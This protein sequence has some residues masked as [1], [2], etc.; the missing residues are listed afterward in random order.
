ML[1]LWWSGWPRKSWAKLPMNFSQ[2]GH[3]YEWSIWFSFFKLQ[4]SVNCRSQPQ[5]LLLVQYGHDV[6]SYTASS[7]YTAAGFEPRTFKTC[8]SP[9]GALTT[10]ATSYSYNLYFYSYIP[11]RTVRPFHQF[12][13]ICEAGGLENNDVNRLKLKNIH[14]VLPSFVVCWGKE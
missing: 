8:M 9:A 12:Q 11:P 2:T 1:Q 3:L 7:Q 5:P 6:V 10:W 13:P 4:H 14:S